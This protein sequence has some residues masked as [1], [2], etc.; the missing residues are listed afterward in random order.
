MENKTNGKNML[1]IASILMLIGGIASAVSSLIGFAAGRIFAAESGVDGAD[2]LASLFT[3]YS[4]VVLVMA[5]FQIVASIFGIAN[6]KKPEKAQACFVMGLILVLIAVF[7]I[8]LSIYLKGFSIIQVFSLVLPLL[9][10]GG[11]RMNRPNHP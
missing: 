10:V 2:A 11:A 5:V 9:Y 4:V 7:S 6:R 1:L 8:V 3:T